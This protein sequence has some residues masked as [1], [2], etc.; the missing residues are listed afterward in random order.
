MAR[1]AISAPLGG[2][3][4]WVFAPK[5]DCT[6]PYGNI[7][8][9]YA[10]PDEMLTALTDDGVEELRDMIQAARINTQTGHTFLD[11]FVDDADL[12]TQIKA[13]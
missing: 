6:K 3:V 10:S 9:V 7:V 12:V 5:T 8:S 4:I 1:A 13:K 11:D 2:D